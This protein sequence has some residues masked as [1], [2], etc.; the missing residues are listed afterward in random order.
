MKDH[1]LEPSINWAPEV[2]LSQSFDLKVDSWSFGTILYHLLT[3]QPHIRISD[4][5]DLKALQKQI[6]GFKLDVEPL[7]YRKVST[8]AIDLV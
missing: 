2:C 4:S 3:G 1:T 5:D 8:Q 6:V 7:K